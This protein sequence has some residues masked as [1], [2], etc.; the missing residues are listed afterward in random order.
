MQ[1]SDKLFLHEDG[2]EKQSERD[3]TA[4]APPQGREL[5]QQGRQQLP[6]VTILLTNTHTAP[7][8]VRMRAY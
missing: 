3:H 4:A 8:H 1:A 2:L 6:A 7:A 5:F